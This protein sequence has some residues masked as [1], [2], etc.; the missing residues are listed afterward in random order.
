MA[1]GD[2]SRILKLQYGKD[3]KSH[4][5]EYVYLGLRIT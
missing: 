4:V 1:M 5:S 2:T 3:T